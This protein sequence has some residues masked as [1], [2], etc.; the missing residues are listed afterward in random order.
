MMATTGPD[1]RRVLLGRSVHPGDETVD[2]QDAVDQIHEGRGVVAGLDEQGDP[3]CVNGDPDEPEL[4]PASCHAQSGDERAGEDPGV[5][6]RP[7]GTHR[8]EDGPEDEQEHHDGSAE[9]HALGRRGPARPYRHSG[10]PLN[11]L[12]TR[13]GSPA[14]EAHK[15]EHDLTG[16]LP[17][18]VQRL[19]RAEDTAEEDSEQEHVPG[20]ADNPRC[21][22]APGAQGHGGQTEDV[23]HNL[24][25]QDRQT[26]SDVEASIEHGSQEFKHATDYGRR[27]VARGPIG[28]PP[29]SGHGV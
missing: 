12:I 24:A 28:Q 7:P 2:A 17:P 4:D 6:Q 14:V 21:D 29:S 16:R 22:A 13:P 19:R 23:S 8:P 1:R 15:G 3:D 9:P 11:G 25:P 10:V 5:R 26:E 18:Q 27:A 20:Q